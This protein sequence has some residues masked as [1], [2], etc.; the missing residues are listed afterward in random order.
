MSYWKYELW[1]IE[2]KPPCPS[3]S[4]SVGLSKIPKMEATDPIF[5]S[6]T[7]QILLDSRLHTFWNK[8]LAIRHLDEYLRYV[9]KWTSKIMIRVVGWT[10][11]RWGCYRLQSSQRTCRSPRCKSLTKKTLFIL[12]TWQIQSDLNHGGM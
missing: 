6:E 2:Y 12:I 4:R 10:S 1:I 9:D 11:D 8:T 5:L 3:F 7:F